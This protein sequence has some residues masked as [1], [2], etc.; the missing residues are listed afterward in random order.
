MF[1]TVITTIQEPSVSVRALAAKL[2]DCDGHLV[3]AGDAKGPS[4]FSLATEGIAI[5]RVRFLSLENQ[6]Q[7]P[8]RLARELPTGH[9]C[10][11]NVAYLDAIAHG[12]T[13]IYE[14]DDDN[15]PLDSWK[16][17]D[18]YLREPVFAY[19]EDQK[20][21]E[22]DKPLTLALSPSN[23]AARDRGEGTREVA[24]LI[25]SDA[26]A[27]RH[28]VK[29]A[30]QHSARWINVYRHF[31]EELIWP[32]GLPLDE[33]HRSMT[34]SA[35]PPNGVTP[36]HSENGETWAPIQQGL[37]D[38]SPDVDAVWRLVLDREFRFEIRDS[39]YLLPG[40]W[41][42]F[43]TQ[44]TWWWPAVYPLLYVPS[45]CSFRMCDIWKSLI[46][47]RCLWELGAGVVFHA[48]EVYQ[49]R[50]PHNLMR[51]FGDEVPGYLK[52]QQIAGILEQIVLSPE[53]S[54]VADNLRRCYTAL[55]HADIFPSEELALV[56]AWLDDL[57]GAR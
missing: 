27:A 32:R 2:V 19:A 34:T 35:K 25:S 53:R 26:P 33:I 45:H 8:F 4:A 44:S 41:C 21:A 9:Y 22:N 29:P 6:L 55:V 15:R 11:K 49:E 37:A 52:N 38:G 20:A 56:D 3:V 7:G 10:R 24:E 1:A 42:P 17:H 46:A 12:A 14:T 48:A 5:D 50:N 30:D 13:C 28:G 43:N 31:S 18:E 51:D 16:L 57:R 40:T 36:V 23:L 47:Q 39:L 54:E